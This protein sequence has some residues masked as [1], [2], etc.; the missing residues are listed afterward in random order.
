M[1]SLEGVFAIFLSLLIPIVA[2][3][4]G[5]IS[6]IKKKKAE[7][8]LR[9]LIIENHTDL[10]TAKQLIEQH[11]PKSYKYVSLRWACVLIGMGCGALIDYLMGLNPDGDM[12]IYFWVIIAF[13]VGLGLL[14][15]FLVEWKLQ[16]NDATGQ[17]MS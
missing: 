17:E 11:E 5:G 8:E 16:R 15:S 12:E 7:A 4:M 6:S 14:A 13:G 2:I 9:R 10:E 1:Y 3:V